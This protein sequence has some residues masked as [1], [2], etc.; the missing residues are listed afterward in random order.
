MIA[1]SPTEYSTVYTVLKTVQAMTKSLDQRNSVVTF[2]LAIYT[3]AK[4]IQWRY[5]EEFETLVVRMGGFH[6]ALNFLSV[7]GKKFEESGI[8]DLLTES[9]VYGSNTTLALLKGKS[10]NRGVRAHKL[11]MEALLRLQWQAFCNWLEEEREDHRLEGVDMRQIETNLDKFKE[12][13]ATG[14]KKKA[15]DVLCN[16]AQ[17][18]TLLLSRFK[19]ESCKSSQLFKVW[20]SYVQMVLVLLRFIRAECKGD[21]RLHLATTAEMTPYVFSMDRTNY[22]CWL[23]VYLA[24][25]HLPED[26]APEVHQEFT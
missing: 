23:P 18:L 13:P 22:S 8:K 6:I 4:E 21:W 17:N 10:Y 9:G 7:I 24:D 3:K 15:F 1:G 19:S 14:E 2:D 25:L 12:S 16:S 5:P 20:N 26:T 11:I